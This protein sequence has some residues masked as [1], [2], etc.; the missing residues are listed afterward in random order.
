M[1]TLKAAHEAYGVA[2]GITQPIQ[3]EFDPK[4]RQNRLNVISAMKVYAFKV[5]AYA[6]PEEPGSETLCSTLL[7]PLTLWEDKASRPEPDTVVPSVVN[8]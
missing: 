7:R 5:L 3:T 4:L 2:L 8:Q 6:D 1:D